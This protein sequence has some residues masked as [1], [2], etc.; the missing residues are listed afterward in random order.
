M[1]KQRTYLRYM[2]LD[3]SWYC[4]VPG[5]VS[6][7]W[8]CPHDFCLLLC[9]VLVVASHWC[10]TF[11]LAHLMSADVWSSASAVFEKSTSINCICWSFYRTLKRSEVKCH[12]PYIAFG[13]VTSLIFL[14][15]F[16]YFKNNLNIF[17]LSLLVISF[18]LSLLT[19]SC[20]EAFQSLSFI[21]LSLCETIALVT[22][23]FPFLFRYC[24]S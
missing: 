4:P 17:K 10:L 21:S 6:L 7:N 24:N 18:G 3:S 5:H 13:H 20:P 19:Q 15:L 8:H 11:D 16:L 2:Q 23:Q 12:W 14:F 9:H 22:M 1:D